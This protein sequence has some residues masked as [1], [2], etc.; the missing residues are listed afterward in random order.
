[1]KY[2]TKYKDIDFDI[3]KFC[4]ENS[5]RNYTIEDGKLVVSGNVYLNDRGMNVLPVKFKSVSGVFDCSGNKL[6]SL[7]GCPSYVGLS[8]NCSRNNL[9]SLN[10]GPKVALNYYYCAKNRLT[11]LEGGPEKTNHFECLYNDI[12]SINYIPS[13]QFFNINNNKLTDVNSLKM[14]YSK[15]I[16]NQEEHFSYTFLDNPLFSLYNLFDNYK[17]FF[18]SLDYDYV[19]GDT[20]IMSRF[21][22]ALSELG[23]KS[24]PIIQGYKYI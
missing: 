3:D 1:M 19:R 7:D 23:Y 24:A 5:I 11:S 9:T 22:D 17:E 15:K 18:K 4:Q 6:V 12:K 20:I 16:S 8:F 2:L 21:E 14:L 10:G 13:S